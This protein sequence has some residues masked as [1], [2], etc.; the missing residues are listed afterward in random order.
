MVRRQIGP[1]VAALAC[2]LVYAGTVAAQRPPMKTVTDVMLVLTIPGSDAVFQAA[3]EPPVKAAGWVAL[4]KQVAP[5][6]ESADLM[7]TPK[8]AVDSEEWRTLARAH[9]TSTLAALAAIDKKDAKA[10][11]DT[12]DA[13]YETCDNCHKRFMKKD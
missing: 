8:Y 4:R 13:L 6:L 10:L 1:A 7:L 9:R 12:S 3:G 5:L 2:V 11:S